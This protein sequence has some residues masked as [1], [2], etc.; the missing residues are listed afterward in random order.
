MNNEITHT[1]ESFAFLHTS[2][3]FLG[4]IL[5]NIS[6]CVLLLDKH[7]NLQ[8][9]NDPLKSIF[10]NK[11]DEDLLYRKCGEAIGCAYQ[12][13]EQKECGKTSKCS[14]CELKVSALKSYVEGKPIYREGIQKPFFN[15]H[16]ERE[17]KELQ[18]S[19]RLFHFKSDK[20]VL[21]IIDDVTRFSQN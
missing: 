16:G 13:E 3:E 6:S 20:Y 1:N 10:S 8:A 15:I 14:T 9:F 19:T 7:L 11:R 18:F 12:I 17:N 21:L 2:E 4:L 5:N